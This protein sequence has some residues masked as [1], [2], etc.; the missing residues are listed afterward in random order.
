MSRLRVCEVW[1]VEENISSRPW[2]LTSP[3]TNLWLLM[4]PVNERTQQQ[5]LQY[6]C[7]FTRWPADALWLFQTDTTPRVGP[8]APCCCACWW[9]RVTC[10]TKPKAGKPHARSLSV[11]HLHHSFLAA[12]RVEKKNMLKIGN[13]SCYVKKYDSVFRW[14]CCSEEACA[15][16][17]TFT[18]ISYFSTSHFN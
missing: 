17:N 14:F 13:S 4:V 10:Q 1:A 9:R 11:H 18:P 3:H 6:A 15:L 12:H 7:V 8:T 5:N 16:T 2:K